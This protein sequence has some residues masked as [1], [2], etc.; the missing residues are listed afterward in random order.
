MIAPG[1][2]APPRATI[3]TAISMLTTAIGNVR[4]FSRFERT[5]EL[6]IEVVRV[7]DFLAPAAGADEVRHDDAVDQDHTHARGDARQAMNRPALLRG[8]VLD[9]VHVAGAQAP[10]QQERGQQTNNGEDGK[11]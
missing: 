10:A 2:A 8:H 1:S 9:V 4:R 5:I 7:D 11:R 3:A 6:R